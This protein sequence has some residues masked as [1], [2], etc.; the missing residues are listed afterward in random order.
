M[1]SKKSREWGRT[2][3][4]TSLSAQSDC[5]CDKLVSDDV[6]FVKNK[7]KEIKITLGEQNWPCS[8]FKRKDLSPRLKDRACSLY[9]YYMMQ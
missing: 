5:L 3:P 2:S 1:K 6:V 4:F 9:H 7:I 8:N